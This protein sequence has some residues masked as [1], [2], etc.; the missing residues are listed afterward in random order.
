MDATAMSAEADTMFQKLTKNGY[1]SGSVLIAQNGQVILNQGYGF[2]DRDKNTPNSPQTKFRISGVIEGFIATAIMMLQEQGKLNVQDKICVYLTDC[3][4]S[5][6]PITLHHLLTHTSAI[7]D[8]TTLSQTVDQTISE[9]KNKPLDFQPGDR[10]SGNAVD[11]TLL[12]KTIEV[13][14]GLSYRTFLQKNFFEPLQMSNTGWSQ[15]PTDLALGY[16]R[17]GNYLA[18]QS[19]GAELYVAYSTV[20]DLYHWDQALHAGE[21]VSQEALDT[22]FTPYTPFPGEPGFSEGYSYSVRP[23]SPRAIKGWGFYWGFTSAILHY[24]DDNI[25]IIILINQENIMAWRV[26]FTA[27]MKLFGK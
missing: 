23:F 5:W 27:A 3:P 20:E 12:A 9:A 24:P 4:D 10:W 8:T 16:K 13:V 22:M 19:E 26:A 6:K 1:F 7:P 2:A 25:T 21:F 18:D 15:N 11:Y 17:T 14:S